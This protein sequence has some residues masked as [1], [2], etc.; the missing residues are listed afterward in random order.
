M[1]FIQSFERSH[2]DKYYARKD[3]IDHSFTII[4]DWYFE[5]DTRD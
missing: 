2:G 3:C 5:L 1:E 4:Y